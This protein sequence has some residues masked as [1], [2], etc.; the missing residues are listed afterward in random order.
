MSTC[1]FE[2]ATAGPQVTF[3]CTFLAVFERQKQIDSTNMHAC[4]VYNER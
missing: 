3:L 2:S 1:A 4:I